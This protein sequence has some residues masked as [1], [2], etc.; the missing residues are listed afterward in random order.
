MSCWHVQSCGA[1]EGGMQTNAGQGAQFLMC[2]RHGWTD[3]TALGQ[4]V[5]LL[6]SPVLPCLS[7][8]H[9]IQLSLSSCAQMK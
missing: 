6:V 8:M 7:S 5:L 1:V 3:T 4:S 9:G 2:Y